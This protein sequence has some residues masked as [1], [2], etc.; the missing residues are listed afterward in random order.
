MNVALI[1]GKV[2]ETK[3]RLTQKQEETKK[4]AAPIRE[5]ELLS[6]K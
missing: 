6:V 1:K 5:T 4:E 3:S 2:N